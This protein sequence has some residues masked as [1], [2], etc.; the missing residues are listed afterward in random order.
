MCFDIVCIL[1][2]MSMDSHIKETDMSD[3][4]NIAHATV[5]LGY[6]PTLKE[7]VGSAVGRFYIVAEIGTVRKYLGTEGVWYGFTHAKGLGWVGYFETA[8]AARETLRFATPAPLRQLL[9][10]PYVTRMELLY[11]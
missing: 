2:S 1:G 6:E 10:D 5:R 11:G 7:V 3:S 9:T 8:Q 4:W